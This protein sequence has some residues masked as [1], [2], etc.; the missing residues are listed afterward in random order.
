M[1]DRTYRN[2]PYEN[3]SQEPCDYCLIRA[4]IN[5]MNVIASI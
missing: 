4:Q 3:M 5:V 2:D 1:I